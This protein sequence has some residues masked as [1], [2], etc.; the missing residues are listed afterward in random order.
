MQAESYCRL[1]EPRKAVEYLNK[2]RARAGLG[3]YTFVSEA[4]MIKELQN[5]RA[6]ELGGEFHRK[7]DLVRWG[8]W[9]DQ[10]KEFNE[11]ARFKYNIR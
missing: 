1:G 2:V 10:T 7:F 9:Y 3:E 11:Q 8:I 5:E 6:R 4:D